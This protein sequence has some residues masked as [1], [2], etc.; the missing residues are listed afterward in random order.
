M[1]IGELEDIANGG[2]AAVA[3]EIRLRHYGA[4]ILGS[5]Q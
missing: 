4:N 5:S 3:A 2:P 1:T